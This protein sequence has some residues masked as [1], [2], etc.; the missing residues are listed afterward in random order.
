MRS[1]SLLIMFP[2]QRPE[3]NI[4]TQ[5]QKINFA[6]YLL[7]NSSENS[8][9]IILQGLLMVTPHLPDGLYIARLHQS[10]LCKINRFLPERILIHQ[11]VWN[12]SYRLLA[13]ATLYR[14]N[15]QCKSHHYST[16][17]LY[18]IFICMSNTWKLVDREH[19][20]RTERWEENM[21][22]KILF[23]SGRLNS[24][25]FLCCE[26]NRVRSPSPK[27]NAQIRLLLWNFPHFSEEPAS[28][29]WLEQVLWESGLITFGEYHWKTSFRIL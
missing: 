4:F 11:G 20:H 5:K 9:S 3:N 22:T 24:P 8:R 17:T 7:H 14:H 26:R 19:P 1:Q 23:S 2:L 21:A 27:Y 18:L 28:I 10:A 29:H 6:K 12:C 13:L 16:F 25:E 15:L